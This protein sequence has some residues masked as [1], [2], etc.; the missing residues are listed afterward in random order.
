MAWSLKGLLDRGDVPAEAAA[1]VRLGSG[2][3]FLAWARAVQTGSVVVASNHRLYAVSA[4]GELAVTR[5]WHEVDAAVWQPDSRLL[6]VTWVGQGRASRW[7]FEEPTLLLETVRERVQA[8]VVLA[9]A[10]PLEGRRS[11]RVVIRQDIATGDL[12][13]QVIP[14]NGVRLSDGGLRELV[15]PALAH[16]REQVGLD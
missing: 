5:A 16:L 6:T 14:G 9:E 10:V 4:A 7:L 3:R 8:S 11:A 2:E 1:A 12:L 15:G 13:D